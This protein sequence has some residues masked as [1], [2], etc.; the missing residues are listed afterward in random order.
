[1]SAK[2]MGHDAAV[3]LAAG[4]LADPRRG[5]WHDAMAAALDQMPPEV[6]LDQIITFV[7]AY[8]RNTSRCILCNPT[9]HATDPLDYDAIRQSVRMVPRHDTT[10]NVLIYPPFI[11]TARQVLDLFC[12]ACLAQYHIPARL[13]TTR[14]RPHGALVPQ[15]GQE[16]R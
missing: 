7:T 11:S 1:M 16:V 15:G 6:S 12:N 5:A 10:H 9:L 3:E 8:L 13:E 2:M 4:E 14:T